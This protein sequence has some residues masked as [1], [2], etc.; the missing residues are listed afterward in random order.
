[1]LAQNVILPEPIVTTEAG[2]QGNAPVDKSAAGTD[3]FAKTLATTQ[4]QQGDRE[5]QAK[6]TDERKDTVAKEA[7]SRRNDSSGDSESG[8]GSE[9]QA[10]AKSSDAENKVE[11]KESALPSEQA[12]LD[13]ADKL[14]ELTSND[15]TVNWL[16][17]F[18]A[19]RNE[20]HDKA[21]DNAAFQRDEDV[22]FSKTNSAVFK[23]LF[24]DQ[25]VEQIETP[26]ESAKVADVLA[27]LTEQKG[28]KPERVELN[29]EQT[30]DNDDKTTTTDIS[31]ALNNQQ[32][33]MQSS[34]ESD[35]LAT[36]NESEQVTDSA[37]LDNS[38]STGNASSAEESELSEQDKVILTQTSVNAVASETLKSAE[39]D[40]K[41]IEATTLKA[42]LQQVQTAASVNSQVV[43][44][45]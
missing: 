26:D 19:T 24:G 38:Q 23:A 42:S 36:T 21:N 29:V 8:S 41:S 37:K 20:Q 3:D 43:T 12:E 31:D 39:S 25:P 9:P 10:K 35:A 33:V 17:Q 27:A 44:D 11:S 22:A 1:M 6:Q 5:E 28:G 45:D 40:S 16:Q 14:A 4:R 2:R 7:N 34:A 32:G 18:L 13:S 15:V 30:I